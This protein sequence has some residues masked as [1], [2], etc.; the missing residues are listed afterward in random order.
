MDGSSVEV[1][2][3]A[4]GD[5]STED[6]DDP[7]TKKRSYD[8]GALSDGGQNDGGQGNTISGEEGGGGSSVNACRFFQNMTLVYNATLGWIFLHQATEEATARV[9]DIIK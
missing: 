4:S 9:R 8:D 6:G 3:K 7:D 2:E 5:S 1:E